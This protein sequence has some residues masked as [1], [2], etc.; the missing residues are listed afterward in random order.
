MADTPELWNDRE[1]R[2]GAI[3]R[4]WVELQ[5]NLLGEQEGSES[6]GESF[7]RVLYKYG[8]DGMLGRVL[9]AALKGP[10]EQKGKE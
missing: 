1:W 10:P 7:E 5:V 3:H 6:L 2:A 4:A 8:W 9:D